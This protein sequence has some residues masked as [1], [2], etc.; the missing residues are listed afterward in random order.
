MPIHRRPPGFHLAASDLGPGDGSGGVSRRRFLGY[1]LAGSTVVAAAPLGLS[2]FDTREAAASIPSPPQ[3]ADVVDLTDIL[4]YAA[5]PTANLITVVVNKNGT[6]SFA[7]PRVESGQGITTSTAMLIAEELDLPVHKVHV[8]LADARPELV[9]NQFTAGSSTTTDTYTAIR[10]AAALARQQLLQ[11]AAIELGEDI[12]S[13]ETTAGSVIGATGTLSYGDLA[14][15]A[16]SLTSSTQSVTLKPNSQFKVIGTPQRRVDALDAVTGKKQFTLDI[17]VPGALPA[18]VCRPPTIN[19]TVQSVH[20]AAAVKAMSGITDV[21]NIPTFEG[22][23]AVA[24]VGRTFG[25]CIDAVRALQVS[26]GGGSVDNQS[27]ATVHQQLKAAQLPFAPT[28]PLATVVDAEFTYWSKSN[29]A[30]EPQTAIA[31]VRANGATIWAA[32]QAPI[33]VKSDVAAATGLPANAVTVHV[34]LGG[35]AFGRR[36]FSNVMVEAAHISKAAGKPVKL[37]WDRTAEFRWGRVHPTCISAIRA[38]VLGDNVLT[39]E[40]R[41]T[42]VATDYTEGFGEAL[43]AAASKFPLQNLLEYSEA[44]YN[45]TATVPYNFGVVDQTLLEI[46]NYDTFHTCSVRNLYSPDVTCSVELVVDQLA[47]TMGKDPYQFRRSFLKDPRGIAVLD[48]AAQ[49][50]GW[51]RSLPAGVAQGIAVH[52]EYHG[53]TACVSEID[54]RPQTVNRPAGSLGK[55]DPKAPTVT[56][57]RV[58][59]LTYV[60]DAG[61]AINPLGLQAQMMGGCMDGIGEVLTHSLHLVNGNYEEGSWDQYFYTRQ[62]NTPLELNIVVMPPTTGEPGGAG[63]FGVAASKAATAC[64]LARATGTMPTSFPVNH[65]GP[66]QFDDAY[67]RVPSLPQSPTDGLQHKY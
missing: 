12:G 30:L 26:W 3:L 18:M 17:D 33:L 61:L 24:V 57:P 60:V 6:A 55:P 14:T 28:L 39:F 5:L 10:V 31:D 16:A 49:V 38:S 8:T 25:Q 53:W 43:T 21:V 58:N 46:F 45:S 67:P 11:A 62:W 47:R 51:G 64:A 7:L 34:T 2:L 15:K 27:D 1:V 32:C 59:R 9:A 52:N 66:L 63:E 41:H 22:G 36:M 48:K 40:Q 37:M 29:S 13:L 35:G 23:S 56:G 44:I 19:G 42:S 50:G 20:N 65:D 54:T 4:Y